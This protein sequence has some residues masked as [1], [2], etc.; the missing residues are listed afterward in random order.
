M[1]ED[2]SV[3]VFDLDGT[4]VD[5]ALD[6]SVI[7]K[8]LLDSFP[9][10]GITSPE[11]KTAVITERIAKTLGNE[12]KKAAYRMVR[13]FE[14]GCGM[15]SIE[16]N[17]ALARELKKKGKKF[18]IFS[19]NCH[20]TIEECLRKAGIRDIFDFI[21][22]K[23][24]VERHKPHPEGLLKIMSHFGAPKEKVAFV[25]NEEDD[26][27]AGKSAGIETLIV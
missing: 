1:L 2:K 8:R 9:G 5:I 17:I 18:A 22:G 19:S 20:E 7:R 15:A 3:V 23:E 26:T 13:E 21:V 10:T 6:W 14:R 16:G 12:Q 4:L 27:E 11:E 24:D 25:G